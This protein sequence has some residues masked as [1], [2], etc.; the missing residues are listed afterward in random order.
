MACPAA[1]L[2]ADICYTQTR[3]PSP[4]ASVIYN[5]KYTLYDIKFMNKFSSFYASP[6]LPKV[7][8]STAQFESPVAK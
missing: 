4:Y 1:A 2:F 3:L 7:E 8:V 5:L 6:G